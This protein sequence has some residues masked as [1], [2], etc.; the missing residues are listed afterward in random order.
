[1]I[2]LEILTGLSFR[3]AT[4]SLCVVLQDTGGFQDFASG[5]SVGLA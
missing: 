2:I 5:I 1:M 3:I 4:L